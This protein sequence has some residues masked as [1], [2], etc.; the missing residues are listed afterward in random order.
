MRSAFT[1]LVRI[2]P[3]L[4][5]FG[6]GGYSAVAPDVTRNTTAFTLFY[7]AP[8]A[9][10]AEA[11]ASTLGGY[12]DY[13]QAVAANSTEA[14]SDGALTIAIADLVPFDSWA[15]WYAAL[16]VNATGQVG[17]NVEIGSRLLPRDLITANY[18]H[19]AD[20][21]LGISGGATY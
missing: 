21:L 17:A 20:T 19:V 7:I 3:A 14:Q 15:E 13:V 6:W 18:T 16:F 8:N 1:E 2:T 5:D 10:L 12:L 9:S 4:T 11:N